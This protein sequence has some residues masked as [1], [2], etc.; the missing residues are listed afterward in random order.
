M[1]KGI[2]IKEVSYVDCQGGGQVVV[3]NNVAY[4]G[5]MS[6]FKRGSQRNP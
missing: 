3:Q 2:G 1:G 5:N 4:V 6:A